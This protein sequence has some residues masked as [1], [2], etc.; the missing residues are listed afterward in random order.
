MQGNYEP[1]VLTIDGVV[2]QLN[3]NELKVLLIKRRNDPFKDHW[4]LPGGYNPEGET[5]T[6]AL[7]RILKIKAGINVEDAGLLE[8]LYTF[9]A[10]ARD[11]R[12]HSVS[13]VYMALGRKL[14]PNLS[15]NTESPTFFPVTQ[16]PELPYDH[17]E[18]IKY[19][20][21]RLHSK[22]SYTT[23]VSAMLPKHFTLTQLQNAYQAILGRQL[24]K[25]NFRKKFLALGTLESTNQYHREGA[26]RPALLYKFKSSQ[27]ESLSKDFDWY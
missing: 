26:H 15:K 22:I 3:N 10:V 21:E 23:A 14:V 6:E 27:L 11:P 20:R 12:G 19:A 5:T 8:Q 25:R 2:F 16:L 17:N 4:A 18:I 9:D 13:V 1:P 24:D 7:K